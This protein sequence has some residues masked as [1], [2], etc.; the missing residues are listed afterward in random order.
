MKTLTPVAV[1]CLCI[2]AASPVLADKAPAVG[3]TYEE[4]T[5]KPCSKASAKDVCSMALE[6]GDAPIE[7][8]MEGKPGHR[9]SGVSAPA[10]NPDADNAGKK[11]VPTAHL[12]SDLAKERAQLQLDYEN[13]LIDLDELK[14]ETIR[15]D[16]QIEELS[17]RTTQNDKPGYRGPSILK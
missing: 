11:P 9:G 3:A 13:G 12:L 4:I 7:D 6:V 5:E 2:S 14:K 17:E 16:A 1:M 8:P 15:L 10:S